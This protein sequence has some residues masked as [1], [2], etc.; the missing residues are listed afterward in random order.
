VT[1]ISQLVAEA[2]DGSRHFPRCS[3]E[4]AL[5]YSCEHVASRNAPLREL[6]RRD[7]ETVVEEICTVEDIDIPFI[8]FGRRNARCR[9]WADRTTHTIGFTRRNPTLD[10]VIH[11]IAH[12]VA[13]SDRHDDL[14][15][16]T[17]VRLGR[18]HAGV[19][20]ASL[21]HHLFVGVGLDQSGW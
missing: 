2:R 5:V 10:D 15:R 12:L 14:F 17:L 16:S 11:E 20:W 8:E 19:E 6:S 4:Q 18:R 3:T 13:R 7:V 9:A 21:V 1:H